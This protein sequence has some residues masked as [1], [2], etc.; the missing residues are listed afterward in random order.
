MPDE[1]DRPSDASSAA[2]ASWADVVVPDDISSLVMDVAA[3]HRELRRARRL[4]WR[5]R[6][7]SRPGVLPLSI[8]SVGLVLA[9]VVATLLTVLSPSTRDPSLARL[10]LA[11][12]GVAAVGAI[13]GLLPQVTLTQDSS[14]V[15]SR[16]MRPA[17]VAL[18]PVNCN[19]TPLLN[20]VAGEAYGIDYPLD[21]VVSPSTPDLGGEAADLTAGKPQVLLDANYPSNVAQSMYGQLHAAGLTFVLVERDGVIYDIQRSV[22]AD[23]SLNAELQTMHTLPAGGS[24]QGND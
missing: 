23:P 8:M 3:Y 9:G 14:P 15:S 16:S 10:P 20:A 11:T 22:T 12:T 2:D 4:A 5:T 13:G 24:H 1:D 19:C 21:V 17:V 6:V 7:L 18:V